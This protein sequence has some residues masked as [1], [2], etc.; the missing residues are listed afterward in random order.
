MGAHQLDDVDPL[1]QRVD[2]RLGN[3]GVIV[4]PNARKALVLA[5][6]QHLAANPFV[7]ALHRRSLLALALGRG[8]L[9]ELAG[10]ELIEQADFLD[11]ALKAPHGG[12]KGLVFFGAD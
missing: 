8:L 9:V 1:E 12:F 11:G 7:M 3:H 4:T 10:A 2:E 5:S 6:R